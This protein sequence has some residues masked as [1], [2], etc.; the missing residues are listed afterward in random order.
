M[1]VDLFILK[2]NSR[3]LRIWIWK[4]QGIEWRLPVSEVWQLETDA[5]QGCKVLQTQDVSVLEIKLKNGGLR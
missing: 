1:Y 4:K 3:T 2:P 5:D